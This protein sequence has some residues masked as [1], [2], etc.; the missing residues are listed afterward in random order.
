MPVAVGVPEIVPEV[1]RE[2]PA[3]RLPLVSCQ[4]YGA[5]PY[6]AFREFW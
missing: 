3:G 2:S 5:V 4:L 6:A 1:L